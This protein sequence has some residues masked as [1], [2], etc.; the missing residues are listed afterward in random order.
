MDQELGML[1]QQSIVGCGCGG[2]FINFETTHYKNYR[3]V[4]FWK[5]DFLPILKY[6]QRL[7]EI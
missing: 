1:D 4:K 2:L 3:K 7:I 5:S 6:E